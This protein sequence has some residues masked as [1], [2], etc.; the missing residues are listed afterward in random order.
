MFKQ[1]HVS[2]SRK[3]G[4]FLPISVERLPQNDLQRAVHA[5]QKNNNF[6]KLAN[7]SL[8][9]INEEIFISKLRDVNLE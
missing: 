3:A 8:A 6:D 1:K 7:L 2:E 4:K 5:L 9:E